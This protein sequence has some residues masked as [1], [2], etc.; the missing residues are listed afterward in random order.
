MTGSLALPREIAPGVHW[1][2]ACLQV[3]Y[4]GTTLHGYN[5][6]YLVA[7][8]ECSMLVEA[9]HPQ[10]AQT[11]E[12][13][14][15]T[16]LAA[17]VP[18]LRYLFTTHTEAPHAGAVGRLLARYP[19]LQAC[20]DVEDL[21]LVFPAYAD[22]LVALEPG[23][24]IDLGM[25]RLETVEAV[26]RDMIRT[27]W[28]FDRATGVLFAGD[29]FAYSHYHEQG[30]CGR[31]AEEVPELDV[32]EMTALFAELAFYWTRFVDIEPYIARLDELIFDELAVR[33]L[34]P[35]HGL[36]I[37]DPATTLARVRQGLRWGSAGSRGTV[38]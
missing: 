38:S 9:G 25:R 21:H 8:E 33:L 26:F 18:P 19:D 3:A 34:A 2:G 6:V 36:P 4:R 7:G 13:Q 20:G 5:S 1:L 22:R 32:P 24:T 30:Q 17:G 31:M 12:A 15:E 29:G 28:L 10:D 23:E 35:T 11:I 14:I 16:L 37:T 27:R